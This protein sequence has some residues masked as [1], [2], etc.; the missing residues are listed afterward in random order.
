METPTLRRMDD[1]R[2]S[3]IEDKIDLILEKLSSIPC[4]ARRVEIENVKKD[5][6]WI[7][8]I[9]MTFIP[10]AVGATITF[11]MMFVATQT[12]VSHNVKLLEEFQHGKDKVQPSVRMPFM[13][14]DS[15]FASERT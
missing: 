8:K 13:S 6:G 10:M 11:A 5:I 9:L 1:E 4:E 12:T 3:K 14:I 2:I 7:Q 15:A